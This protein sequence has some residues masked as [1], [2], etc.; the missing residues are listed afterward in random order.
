MTDAYL[1]IKHQPGVR[2]RL[3]SY[4]WVLFRTLAGVRLTAEPR[5]PIN[6]L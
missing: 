2:F 5:I 3:T 1:T 4:R 6:I